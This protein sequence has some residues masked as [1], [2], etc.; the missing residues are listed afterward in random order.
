MYLIQLFLPL[1]DNDGAP[2]PHALFRQVRDELVERFGGL[3][4]H[5]RSPAHGLWQEQDGTTV[6]DDLVVYE[7]MVDDLDET[8]WRDFRHNLEQHFKQEKIVVRAHPVRLL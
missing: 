1:Y 5:S 7:V 4:A 6:Q 3:T 8:W 2:I